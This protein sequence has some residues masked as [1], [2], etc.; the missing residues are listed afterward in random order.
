MNIYLK[1]GRIYAHEFQ[2]ENLVDVTSEAE[3]YLFGSN[4][5]CEESVLGDVIEL[6]VNNQLLQKIFLDKKKIVTQNR[7][8]EDERIERILKS[9]CMTSKFVKHFK[10]LSREEILKEIQEKY[11]MEPSSIEVVFR[12]DFDINN[13]LEDSELIASMIDNSENYALSLDSV[14]KFYLSPLKIKSFVFVKNPTKNDADNLD[15]NNVISHPYMKS[16][17]LGEFLLGVVS[18]LNEMTINGDQS[19]LF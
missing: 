12:R 3:K 5:I 14:T 2:S 4:V 10:N 15:D 8:F 17:T 7:K 9:E 6:F 11:D 13:R 19:E 18:T 1:N 16:I